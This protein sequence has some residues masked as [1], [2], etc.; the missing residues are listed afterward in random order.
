MARIW[1]GRPG[2]QPDQG[3]LKGEKKISW[4]KKNLGPL[5]FI[6]PLGRLPKMPDESPIPPSMRN[7][8]FVVVEIDEENGDLNPGYYISA[9][10]PKEVWEKLWESGFISACAVSDA[11][12]DRPTLSL[13]TPKLVNSC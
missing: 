8:K 5:T 3:D 13:K 11:S 9:F 4:C 10:T 1:F 6:S 12:R 7:Y 2:T